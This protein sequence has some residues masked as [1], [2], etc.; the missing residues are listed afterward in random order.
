MVVW[1]EGSWR[2]KRTGEKH[3]YG[4]SKD[5]GGKRV[6]VKETVLGEMGEHEERKGG[7]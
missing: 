1:R 4:E 5:D 7:A 2:K 6:V 3:D